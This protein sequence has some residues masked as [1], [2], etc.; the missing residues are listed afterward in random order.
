VAADLRSKKFS[1]KPTDPI[2]YFVTGVSENFLEARAALRDDQYGEYLDWAASLLRAIPKTER[3]KPGHFYYLGGFPK[4]LPEVPLEREL[5]WLAHVLSQHTVD[6]NWFLEEMAK[7]ETDIIHDAPDLARARL[8]GI[9]KCLGES[10]WSIQHRLALE[11]L[12]G[13]LEAQKKLLTV[14]RSKHV[15]GMLGFIA[16][17]TSVRNEDR[18]SWVA[19]ESMVR[20]RLE[21]TPYSENLKNYINFKLTL[22]LPVTAEGI[23]DVLRYEQCGSPIDIYETFLSV[24]QFILRN[25]SLSHIRHVLSKAIR[26]L[27][28]ITDV[29]L[30]KLRLALGDEVVEQHLPVRSNEASDAL[31]RGNPV[32]ALKVSRRNMT[33]DPWRVIYAAGARAQFTSDRGR[34]EKAT[35]GLEYMIASIL[36]RDESSAVSAAQLEKLTRNLSGIPFFAGIREFHSALVNSQDFV[37]FPIGNVCLHSRFVGPEDYDLPV[38]RETQP[39]LP[40]HV[41]LTTA[42]WAVLAGTEQNSSI[43][44]DAA[45]FFSALRFMRLEEPVKATATLGG[46]IVTSSSPPIIRLAASL[47]LECYIAAGDRASIIRLVASEAAANELAPAFLPIERALGGHRWTDFKPHAADLTA[48]IALDTLWRLT[49]K[50]S[51]ATMLR[52]A[53]SYQLKATG[54]TA[55]S[56]LSDAVSGVERNH[57]LYY[58]RNV[59]VPNVMDMASVFTS[60]KQVAEE[61]QSVCAALISLDP[62]RTE[63]YQ[64]EIL[65]IT[66]RQVIVDGLKIVDGSRIHVDTPAISRWAHRHLEEDFDRYFDLVRAGIGATGDF[67]QILRELFASIGARQVYFTPDDQSDAILADI[68]YRLRDEFLNNSDYGLD[69]FLSKRVRHQSFIGLIRGPLEFAH[70]ITSKDSEFGSYQP[71]TYWTTRLRSLTPDE[72]AAVQACFD[73]FATKFDAELISL[74]DKFLQIRNGDAPNGLFDIELTNQILF[75]IRNV[76]KTGFGLND[77]LRMVF[78]LFWGAL[79]PSLAEARTV[80]GVKLKSDLRDMFD[81]LRGDLHEVAGIDPGFAELS[82]AIGA[83]SAEVQRNLDDAANWFARPEGQRASHKFTLKQSMEI[84]VES[85]RKSHRVFESQIE[86]NVIGDVELQTADLL[87][88]T[89]TI[90]VALDNVAAHGGAK[91]GAIVEIMCGVDPASDKIF[92]EVRNRV[93]GNFDRNAAEAKLGRLRSLI[94]SQEVSKGA[95]KEGGSGFLKIAAALRHSPDGE[96]QFG[97]DQ[98]EFFIKISLRPAKYTVAV[99]HLP[100]VDS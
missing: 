81:T 70:V 5:L 88:L 20:S 89:D 97:F 21:K 86:M 44:T 82:S 62:A 8:D 41:N 4:A 92:L 83:V 74:K 69:Y 56:Q 30:Q 19:F 17:Y 73:R 64:A 11:H 60:S 7:L 13:G 50:D 94:A 32:E 61:R 6:L 48:L 26:F 25:S 49:E 91:R 53:F 34:Y 52:Y 68:L 71:N 75:I 55:P 24:A 36:R 22:N 51:V 40:T 87:L 65:E 54:L 12:Y 28:G 63:D 96:I 67:D 85:A 27:N 10:Y 79:E 42:V 100:S 66:N 72:T 45:T 59:C 15:R 18:T 1:K 95:R 57:L 39:T 29:R 2:Q 31:L 33:I 99:V 14:Y 43:E 16:Y 90:F 76:I 84:A 80:V 58:W 37:P 77:F 47:L 9:T 78:M 23:A 93:P 35:L 46:L 38:R 98:N 3:G